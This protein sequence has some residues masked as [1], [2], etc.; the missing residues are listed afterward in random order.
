MDV[1]YGGEVIKGHTVMT[2][3]LLNLPLGQSSRISHNKIF[4]CRRG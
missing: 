4:W 3:D 1:V 2:A